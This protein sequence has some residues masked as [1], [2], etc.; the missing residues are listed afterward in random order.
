MSSSLSKR[1]IRRLRKHNR[2]KQNKINNKLK[3]KLF[4]H[5]TLSPCYYCK[6]IFLVEDLTIEHLL[7]LCLGGGN[8]PSNIALAC[9]P[10]NKN[11][12]RLAWFEKQ[13]ENKKLYEQ[14]FAQYSEQNRKR[15]L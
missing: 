11:Q 15:A 2:R 7:A 10:C 6:K 1:E 5:L 9:S 13:K 3:R 14:Y 4:G 12:G 8:D